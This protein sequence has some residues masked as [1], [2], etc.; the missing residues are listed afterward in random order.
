LKIQGYACGM[1][2]EL[3]AERQLIHVDHDHGCCPVKNRSCGG[4]CFATRATLHWATSN[5]GIRWLA[6]TWTGRAHGRY[7]S[8][9]GVRPAPWCKSGTSGNGGVTW[10]RSTL[11]S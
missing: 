10:V 3:F 6:L 11:R 7:S 9:K 2:R 5:I 8:M 1:C 4:D